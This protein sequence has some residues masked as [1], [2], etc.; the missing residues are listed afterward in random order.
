MKGDPPATYS[1]QPSFHEE[2]I[3]CMS[4]GGQEGELAVRSNGSGGTSTAVVTWAGDTARYLKT[5][6]SAQEP[7]EGYLKEEHPAQEERPPKSG[8][9]LGE[10][11][12]PASSALPSC[13][14]SRVLDQPLWCEPGGKLEQFVLSLGVGGGGSSS[15][16]HLSSCFKKGQTAAARKNKGRSK[17]TTNGR[18]PAAENAEL[19]VSPVSNDATESSTVV[20]D[21]DFDDK[22][23][24]DYYT[25]SGSFSEWNKSFDDVDSSA[26]TVPKQRRGRFLI[27]PVGR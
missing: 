16:S 17:S 12:D 9:H 8:C 27:W 15:S 25:Y 13:S 7:V 18:D 23:P 3:H 21:N 1:R 6:R 20:D 5:G 10:W 19:L 24:Y 14:V 26:K 4:I 22:Y 2:E 11:C